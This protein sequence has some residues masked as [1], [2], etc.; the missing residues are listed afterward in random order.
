MRR[1]KHL[2]TALL[3]LMLI[4]CSS[5]SAMTLQQ[6]RVR[7]QLYC[8]VSPDW[9]GFSKAD[10]EGNWHGLNVDICRAVAAAVIGDKTKVKFVPLSDKDGIGALL[11][12]KVDLLSTNLGWSL[13]YDTSIGINFC[14]VTFYDGIG[15]MVPVK[16][17]VQSALE[18]DNSIMWSEASR[19]GQVRLTE[20]F[21]SHD[22]SVNSEEPENRR[23]LL[24]AFESGR[25]DAISANTSA[26]AMLR[27]ELAEPADYRILPETISRRPLGPAV[28]QGDDGWFN[29]VRWV[30]FMLKVA[31]MEGLTSF[32]V[33]AMKVT[34]DVDMQSLLGIRGNIGKGLGLA[35]DWVARMIAATGSYGEIFSRNLGSQSDIKLDRNLNEIWS[36][37][38]LHYAPAVD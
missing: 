6:V 38:G 29:I 35:N 18:L 28:S 2:F 36:R 30:L 23:Q 14:G 26:L 4:V 22:L 9:A 8:G 34:T 24:E 19:K 33:E 10:S 17:G 31:E 21:S 13:R 27:T 32:N 20:F 37:G 12:G 7:D 15:F 5:A 11:T 25:C 3:L 1:K 16:S